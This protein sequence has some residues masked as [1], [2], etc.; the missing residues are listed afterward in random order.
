MKTGLLFAAK[1]EAATLLSCGFFGWKKI[2]SGLYDSEK[3]NSMLCIGGIGHEKAV[4]AF[5]L[6]AQKCNRIFIF[7]TCAALVSELPIFT[8]C[9]PISGVRHE[10]SSDIFVPDNKLSSELTNILSSLKINFRTDLK[11][12]STDKIVASKEQAQNLHCI[13]EAFI[14]DMESATFLQQAAIHHIPTA[15]LKVIS[16]N[17]AAGIS[18]LDKETNSSLNKWSENTAKISTY[19]SAIA[20]LLL[21]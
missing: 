18:P 4:N 3:T 14:A 1:P 9:V 7:G 8:F 16:D 10:K 17:P 20:K 12:T 19:F 13:T 2:G 11:L 6:S 15:I 21:S 5:S